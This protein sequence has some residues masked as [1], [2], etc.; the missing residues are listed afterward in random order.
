MIRNLR[1][2]SWEGR[3]YW[4]RSR[5][6]SRKNQGWREHNTGGNCL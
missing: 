3:R 6:S 4:R 2:Q 5:S 1:R